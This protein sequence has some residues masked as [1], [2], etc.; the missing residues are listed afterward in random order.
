TWPPVEDTFTKEPNRGGSNTLVAIARKR[1]VEAPITS[2][3]IPFGSITPAPLSCEVVSPTARRGDPRE[4]T[5]GR[6]G[7]R[8]LR[9]RP[10]GRSLARAPRPAPPGTRGRAGPGRRPPSAPGASAPRRR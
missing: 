10:S 5:A 7:G 3:I 1:V 4:R 2:P 8:R 6:P 9:G